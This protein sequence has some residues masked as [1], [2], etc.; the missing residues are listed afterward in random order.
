MRKIFFI[1]FAVILVQTSFSVSAQEARKDRKSFDKEAFEARRNAFIVTE[2]G[3]T[4]EEAERFIPLCD[5]LRK[6][7]FEVGREC[8]KLTKQVRSKENPTDADYNEV[9]DKCLEVEIK[10]AELEKEY[11]G[12]N[13]CFVSISCDQDKTAWE[14]MVK[15]KK[16]GGIQ[17]IENENQA[18]TN[19]YTVTTIP[20]FILLDKEG[21]II[22]ADAPRPSE[23]GL[24]ELFDSLE[25]L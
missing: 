5:E 11:A 18:F 20:R 8:R 14:Q 12:R 19:A 3:L 17:L 13:I 6:K 23:P 1:T 24:V 16:L 10:E 7:R 2:V 21:K 25:G 4:P 22:D 15:E 9:I